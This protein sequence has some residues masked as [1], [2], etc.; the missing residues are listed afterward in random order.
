[1]T[2]LKTVGIHVFLRRKKKE[3]GKVPSCQDILSLYI[4]GSTSTSDYGETLLIIFHHQLKD[5]ACRGGVPSP[6]T[7]LEIH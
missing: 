2:V 7:S 3:I 4:R 6:H 1:M 5:H